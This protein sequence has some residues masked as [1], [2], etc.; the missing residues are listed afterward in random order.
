MMKVSPKISAQNQ[1]FKKLRHKFVDEKAMN[2]MTLISSFHWKSLVPFCLR[3]KRLETALTLTMN[4][5]II[6][7]KNNLCYVK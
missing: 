2:A 3:K 7:Q 4:Y 5:H 6:T 1:S